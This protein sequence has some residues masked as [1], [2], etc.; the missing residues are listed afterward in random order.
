MGVPRAQS[1]ERECG[2]RNRGQGAGGPTQDLIGY[3]LELGFLVV[4]VY[5]NSMA[6]AYGMVFYM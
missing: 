5:G 6:M 1:P 3:C 4:L 2:A